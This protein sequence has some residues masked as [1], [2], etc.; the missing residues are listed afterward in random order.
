MSRSNAKMDKR[1]GDFLA[2]AR[3]AR[4][5]TLLAVSQEL[6]LKSPQSIWDWEN[7]KGSGIPADMLLRLVRLYRI[8]EAEAYEQLI[9]FHRTRAE[10]KSREKFEEARRQLGGRKKA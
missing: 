8:S 9:E 1:L 3:N 2:K 5:L 4:R 10:H 7:G 6:G